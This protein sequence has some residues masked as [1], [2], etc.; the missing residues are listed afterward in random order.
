MN[1]QEESPLSELGWLYYNQQAGP[2]QPD[3]QAAISG[4]EQFL[5]LDSS[6]VN[7][8]VETPKILCPVSTRLNT[9]GKK[10]TKHYNIA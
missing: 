9:I 6:S 3:S 8:E 7:E 5:P 10:L 2:Q 1:H 4:V